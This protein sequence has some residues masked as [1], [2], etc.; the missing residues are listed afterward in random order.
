MIVFKNKNNPNK[1]GF[2]LPEVLL[3]LAIIA[4]ILTPIFIN[5]AVISRNV[6]RASRM[7]ARIFVAKKILL[8]S[9]LA[10]A[11]EIQELKSEKKV[12][13]PR[14]TFLYE[15]KK[16]SDTSALKNFKNVLIE[17]ISWSDTPVK[18][19]QDRLVTLLYKPE[20]K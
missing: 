8:E 18:G 19:K 3:S 12:D 2:T 16:I 7:L 17:S 5:Q 11:P 6:G 4:L 14:T 1:N 15:L 20:Q 10:L 9:E 13:I